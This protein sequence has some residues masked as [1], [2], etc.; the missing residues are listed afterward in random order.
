M[1]INQRES[2]NTLSDMQVLIAC[3]YL[4]KGIL[5]L[6]GGEKLAKWLRGHI[7]DIKSVFGGDDRVYIR[8]TSPEMAKELVEFITKEKIG[9]EVEWVKFKGDDGWYLML[10]WD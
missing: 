4:K 2:T 8:L 5:A 7:D 10:W 9:D 1:S 6:V 3:E